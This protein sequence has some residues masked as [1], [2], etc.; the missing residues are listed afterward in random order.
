MTTTGPSPA[1]ADQSSTHAELV[2]AFVVAH[3]VRAAV[4]GKLAGGGVE[5]L[6][7]AL[8]DRGCSF[9][10]GAKTD[11]LYAQLSGRSGLTR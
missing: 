3:R 1:P 2:H 8:R 4:G 11:A 6:R 7:S 10:M 5:P 9:E